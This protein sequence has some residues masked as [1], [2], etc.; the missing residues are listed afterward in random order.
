MAESY[1][2]KKEIAPEEL[3]GG[4][5]NNMSLK[6]ERDVD[7]ENCSPQELNK[8]WQNFQTSLV[9]LLKL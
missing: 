9:L 3:Q 1:L 5:T 7:I 8:F 6:R 4:L 2:N